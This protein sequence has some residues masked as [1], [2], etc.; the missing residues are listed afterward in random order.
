MSNT[1]TSLDSF[2]RRPV[3]TPSDLDTFEILIYDQTGHHITLGHVEW[4]IAKSI[5]PWLSRLPGISKVMASADGF[6]SV[7]WYEGHISD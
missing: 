5:A 3:K 4:G 6:V 2:F 7:G 1:L